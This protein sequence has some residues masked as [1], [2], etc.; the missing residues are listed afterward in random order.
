MPRGVTAILFDCDK[1]TLVRMFDGT[2][3]RINK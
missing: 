3:E 1:F 2:V